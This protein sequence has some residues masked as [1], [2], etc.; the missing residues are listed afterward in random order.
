METRTG[1]LQSESELAGVERLYRRLGFEPDEG[2]TE[3]LRSGATPLRQSDNSGRHAVALE[4]LDAA[5]L[6]YPC[7]CTRRQIAERVGTLFGDRAMAVPPDPDAAAAMLEAL[8]G[9]FL[10]FLFFLFPSP[11]ESIGAVMVSVSASVSEIN[12]ITV[13]TGATP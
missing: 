10:D 4:R 2:T 9:R 7:T 5:G 8:V 12:V 13:S 3:E 6:V 11:V 1:P